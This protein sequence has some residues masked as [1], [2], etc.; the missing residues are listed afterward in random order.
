MEEKK[1]QSINDFL[2]KQGKRILFALYDKHSICSSELADFLNIS[3]NSMSNALDRLKRAPHSLI[4]VE[5]QGRQNLYTLTELGQVYVETVLKEDENARE[6][7]DGLIV[8]EDVQEDPEQIYLKTLECLKELDE[9]DGEWT[10][11]IDGSIVLN[12]GEKPEIS[13]KFEDF[14][15]LLQ[16][17]KENEGNKQYYAVLEKLQGLKVRQY[18]DAIVDR[19][20]G[21]ERLWEILD[22]KWEDGYTII[23]TLFDIDKFLLEANAIKGLYQIIAQNDL[24][25]LIRSMQELISW[26]FEKG[27]TQDEFQGL[28]RKEGAPDKE[29]VWYLGA[30]Y[31]ELCK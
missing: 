27:Y 21:L 29:Y 14:L 16:K 17:L 28:L 13:S 3:R 19:R 11:K 18:I 5:K 1:I 2:T 7:W 20:H 26:A 22:D 9:I 12:W 6:L 31:K 25:H 24:W 10:N 30:K 15:S 23:N 8:K 4:S